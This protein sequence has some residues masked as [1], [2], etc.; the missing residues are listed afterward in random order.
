M[1]VPADLEMTLSMRAAPEK[2]H[3]LGA[4]ADDW[5]AAAVWLRAVARKS[6][7]SSV[8]TI[9]TYGYHLA[10]LR[11]YCENV[12]RITP[13]RWSMQEVE[14]FYAFLGICQRTQFAHRA[15]LGCRNPGSRDTRPFASALP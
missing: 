13:S 5:E 10:K 8:A 2:G 6:G 7:N 11:W 14:A 3:A 9:N 15:K 12:L 1:S 4:V